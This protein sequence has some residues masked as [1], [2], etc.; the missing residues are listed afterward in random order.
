MTNRVSRAIDLLRAAR[1][2][3]HTHLRPKRAQQLQRAIDKVKPAVKPGRVIY[4]AIQAAREQSKNGPQFGVG[5]CLMQVRKCYGIAAREPDATSAWRTARVK[6]TNMR[7]PRGYPLFWTGGSAGHGHIAI[8][9]GDGNCWS[10]DIDRP[11]FFDLCPIEQIAAQWGLTEAG[12]AEDI[13]GVTVQPSKEVR[14]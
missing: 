12:W 1:H 8:A 5:T 2:W 7:A 6:H 3:S 14:K 4:P 11:G 13:N 10:T 9:T